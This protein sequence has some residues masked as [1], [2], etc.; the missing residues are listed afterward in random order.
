M[1]DDLTSYNSTYASIAL[2][3]IIALLIGWDVIADYR[4]NAHWGH[5]VVELFVLLVAATAYNPV[6]PRRCTR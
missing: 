6:R 1:S 5:M 4:E 2:F 3:A